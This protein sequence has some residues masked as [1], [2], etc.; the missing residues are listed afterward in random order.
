MSVRSVERTFEILDV[1]AQHLDGVGVSDVAREVDL[2]KS[3]VSRLLLTLEQLNVVKR[4]AD[5]TG[6]VLGD[7]LYS[8]IASQPYP[9][10]IIKLAR[11]FMLELNGFV[12]EDIGL[13]V[14]DGECVHFIDQVHSHQRV[15]QVKD[16]TDTRFPLHTSSSGKLFLAYMPDEVVARY[17]SRPLER[18]TD[19]T[20]TDPDAIRR[21]LALIRERGLD[22]SFGEFG[23]GFASV[24][25]PVFDG[26]GGVIA[27]LNIY[28]PAFRFPQGR[29]KEI[30]A[31]ILDVSQRFSKKI[32]K[33]N[34]QGQIQKGNRKGLPLHLVVS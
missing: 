14:P 16:W 10:H 27:G 24:S 34:R 20:L 31:F 32:Q 22:W 18:Y 28:A 19:K 11:P 33:G 12:G 3:T 25:A 8:L 17:L 21:N 30:T 6:F 7:R 13:A 1:V 9:D 26:A 23:V 5:N 15:V 2:H 4:A 29:E